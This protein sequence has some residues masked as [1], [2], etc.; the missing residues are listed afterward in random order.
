MDFESNTLSYN[1][2]SALQYGRD[3]KMMN[4]IR[5]EEMIHLSL[6]NCLWSIMTR[7]SHYALTKEVCASLFF[8]PS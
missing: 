8:C 4:L 2:E 3:V 5:R 6:G 7:N 1:N